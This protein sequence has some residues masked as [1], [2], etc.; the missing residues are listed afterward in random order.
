MTIT[1]TTEHPFFVKG[2]GF[3]RAGS[4]G[5]GTQIVTR[6]GPSATVTATRTMTRAAGY[7]V[8]NLTVDGDHAYFVGKL[9]GGVWV[10][11]ALCEKFASYE[12]AMNSALK[13]LDERGFRAQQVNYSKGLG[14]SPAGV[15]NGMM[16]ADGKVGFRVDWDPKKGAHINVFDHNMKRADGGFPEFIFPGDEKLVAKICQRFAPR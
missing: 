5:I 15:P 8:Y 14:G 12:Q 13:W 10:H 3:V 4:L 6:A 1:T 2:R 11:N 7:T 16:T 9:A